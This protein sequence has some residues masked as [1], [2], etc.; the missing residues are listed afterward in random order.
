[1]K[2]RNILK[3]EEAVSPVIATILMVAITVVLAATLYMMLPSSEDQERLLAGEFSAE[4][5]GEDNVV[6][7][8]FDTMSKPASVERRHVEFY[9]VGTEGDEQIFGDDVEWDYLNQN[10]EVRGGSE[11]TVNWEE[12]ENDIGEPESVGIFIDGYEGS[13]IID[14]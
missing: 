7:I 1:M 8:N 14:L 13:R 4:Y 9:F 11:A 12:L 10:D 6:I 2:K 3:N 5:D